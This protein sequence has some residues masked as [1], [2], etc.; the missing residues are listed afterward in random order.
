MYMYSDIYTYIYTYIYIYIHICIYTYMYTDMHIEK[1]R[2]REREIDR[3]REREGER[4]R[5]RDGERERERERESYLLAVVSTSVLR[6]LTFSSSFL[7]ETFIQQHKSIPV[8]FARLLPFLARSLSHH[9]GCSTA[10]CSPVTHAP[11]DWC[12]GRSRSVSTTPSMGRRGTCTRCKAVFR[13]APRG[14]HQACCAAQGSTT[15]PCRQRPHRGAQRV[16]RVCP[17]GFP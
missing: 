17:P 1:E 16:Q 3:E 11:W 15:Q 8:A 9:A 10:Q 13:A 2:E 12:A 4:E 7:S 6:F 5:E 14:S